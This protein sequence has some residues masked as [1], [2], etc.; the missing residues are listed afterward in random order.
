MI[1]GASTDLPSNEMKKPNDIIVHISQPGWAWDWEVKERTT[2]S[3]PR[4]S[5]DSVLV[6]KLFFLSLFYFKCM[7]FQ[8]HPLDAK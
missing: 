8:T 7:K 5:C 3:Y 1:T 2:I 4:Y 6:E